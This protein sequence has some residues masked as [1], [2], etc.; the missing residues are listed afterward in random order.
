MAP[1]MPPLDSRG[2][3]GLVKQS[4]RT[5]SPGWGWSTALDSGKPRTPT[6]YTGFCLPGQRSPCNNQKPLP[7]G[8]T[9]TAWAPVAFTVCSLSRATD[10]EC[11]PAGRSGKKQVAGQ[12]SL[13]RTTSSG[14]RMGGTLAEWRRA[15]EDSAW[16]S[17]P[18]TDSRHPGPR[19][20]FRVALP[21]ILT[22]LSGSEPRQ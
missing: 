21:V 6:P 9:K 2:R 12:P 22:L 20:S 14:P 7:A 19:L 10:S 3:P 4:R 18:K 16:M 17:F 13:S 1:G 8:Q 11:G 15:L 5:G